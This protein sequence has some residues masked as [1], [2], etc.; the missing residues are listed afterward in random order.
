[1][2]ITD[3]CLL[4]TSSNVCV[5]TWMDEGLYANIYSCFKLINAYIVILNIMDFNMHIQFGL[6]N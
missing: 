6:S 4:K 1:M 3:L 2:E 5:L